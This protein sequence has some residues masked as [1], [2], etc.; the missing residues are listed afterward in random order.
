M[1]STN[2]TVDKTTF[3]CFKECCLYDPWSCCLFRSFSH[4]WAS[5]SVSMLS[6]K[7]GAYVGCRQRGSS[8]GF[9]TEPV[10]CSNYE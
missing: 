3:G 4:V 6:Q 2:L 9:G 1:N 10:P 5:I 8:L 7:A